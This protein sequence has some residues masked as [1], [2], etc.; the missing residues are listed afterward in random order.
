MAGYESRKP[1]YRDETRDEFFDRL[2]MVGAKD[3]FDERRRVLSADEGIDMG[4]AFRRLAPEFGYQRGPIP[5]HRC[6]RAVPDVP[7]VLNK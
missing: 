7:V 3:L 2:R 6:V 4:E 1:G 5:S